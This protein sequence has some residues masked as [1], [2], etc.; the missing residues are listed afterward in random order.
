MEFATKKELLEYLGKNW[1]DNK[2]VDR[3]MMRGEVKKEDWMYILVDKDYTIH[4]LRGMVKDLKERV[5][6]LEEKDADLL[7]K[8]IEESSGKESREQSREQS[9]YTW[10]DYKDHLKY[11]YDRLL[12]RDEVINKIIQSFYTKN[13]WSYDWD[14]AKEEV[15]KRF[16]F[17]EDPAEQDEL[18]FIS[19]LLN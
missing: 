18:L 3:M 6:E 19:W 10:D 9:K 7:F 14:S 16:W 12:M 11:L 2:L 8:Y 5:K 4:E 1:N 13:S 15:Y 17:V